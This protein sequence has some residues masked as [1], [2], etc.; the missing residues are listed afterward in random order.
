LRT[1]RTPLRRFSGG[2]ALLAAV[3]IVLLAVVGSW[4][5]SVAVD[6]PSGP[7]DYNLV[8]W[9]LEN[10]G[11]KWLY[12]FG[13]IF[14]GSLSDAEKERRVE[15]FFALNREIVFGE[16]VV[17]QADA[18]GT[19]V[20]AEAL[21]TLAAKRERR[22]ELENTVEAILE[23]RVSAVARRIGLE[24]SW[25]F[26]PDFR[27]LFPPVDFEFEEP[28]RV[29]AISPRNVISLESRHLLRGD[30]TV[31]EVIALEKEKE[32]EGVSAL[33]VGV[34]GVGTYP[35]AVPPG[36]GYRQTLE[37]VAH[38][39]LH[40][41]LY[42]YPLGRRYFQDQTLTTINETVANMAGREL[43]DMVWKQYYVPEPQQKEPAAATTSPGEEP[44][45]V[46]QVMRQ[47]RLDVERLLSEGKIDEAEAL[48]EQKRQFL[49]EHGHYIRKI[50]QAYF[51]FYGVYAD[52][53]ASISPIG[54]KLEELRKRSASLGD[55]IRTAA[56]LTSE[57]DLDRLLAQGG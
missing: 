9:E 17:A 15:E 51:A 43:G 42:F 6:L 45:D 56:R 1:L 39:W 3:V 32:A 24:R 33:V 34:G 46:D 23:E 21:A 31:E 8:R 12:E 16:A 18:A 26:F 53:P 36:L 52:T 22:Q 35:S 47:L 30:L 37:L 29:L 54:P 11:N 10:V 13:G 28:P 7:N 27:F 41:Y 19:P 5:I 4:R 14:R 38:E 44:V 57:G 20:G 48:M 25:P 2:P 49:A 50:N 55:F 40:H